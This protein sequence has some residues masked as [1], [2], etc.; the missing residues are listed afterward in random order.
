MPA[1]TFSHTFTNI[2]EFSY[3]CRLH[4]NMMGTIDRCPIDK[5]LMVELIPN[6]LKH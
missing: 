2:G 3:F 1:K 6:F 4:P 5:C